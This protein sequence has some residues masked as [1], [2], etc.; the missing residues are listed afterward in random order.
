MK[1]IISIAA[2]L[3]AAFCLNAQEFT[4]YYQQEYG[5]AHSYVVQGGAAY[6]DLLFQCHDKA[7]AIVVYDLAKKSFAGEIKLEGCKTWHCN[8]AVFSDVFY[9]PGDEFPLLY[10]SQE[11]IAEH[12]TIVFR[13]SRKGSAFNAE[14]VQ[15]IVFPAPI[16]MGLY[17][18]NIALDLKN[19][20]MYLEG[21]T[22]PSWN[23]PAN[24]NGIVL[25]SFDT[26]DVHTPLVQLSTTD[27][28]TR[29]NSDFRVATQGA[30]IRNGYLYQV[31]GGKGAGLFCRTSL[32]NGLELTVKLPAVGIS[33]E[34]E[35]LAFW[36]D[37]LIVVDVKGMVYTSD[38]KVSQQ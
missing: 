20:K 38:I 22:A 15:K 5:P 31:F 34:P 12:C 17:Y 11:N 35:T 1:R 2:A 4:A 14:I 28:K 19:G 18:P 33:E 16:E 32:E 24:G 23:N 29:A 10:V 13:I 6:K 36:N 21:F 26:P 3:A 9:A 7:P 8:N 30:C 37:T 25:L 27:I